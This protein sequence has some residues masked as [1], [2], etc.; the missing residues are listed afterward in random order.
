[1]SR[2]HAW[3]VEAGYLVTPNLSGAISTPMTEAEVDG[4]AETMAE[5]FAWAARGQAA[6]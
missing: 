1:M 6:A 4:L 2:L 5:G 3:L